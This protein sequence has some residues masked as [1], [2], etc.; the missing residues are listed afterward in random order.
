MF[1]TISILLL[2]TMLF[3]AIPAACRAQATAEDT[4]A[5]VAIS[6]PFTQMEQAFDAGNVDALT[7]LFLPTAE[8]LDEAGFAHSGHEELSALFGGFFA[9]FPGAKM[10]IEIESVREIT[11][12]LATG[13][14]IRS[15]TTA[16]GVER[17]ITRSYLTLVREGNA[18]RIAS[19]RDVAADAELSPRQQLEP[20]SWFV[21][22]WIDEGADSLI[23]IKGHWSED[24]NFLLL[25]YVIKREGEEAMASQ[26]RIGWDPLHEQLRS[27]IFDADG[28]F[29]EALWTKISD[30]W[31]VKSSA[32]LP[33]GATGSATFVI[34]PQSE[35]RFV[36]RGLDRI[37][38]DE[39]QP[40]VEMTI[41]RKPPKAE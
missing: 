33:D 19:I 20:L 22:E 10:E 35:D 31:V 9:E 24:E 16:D 18:W 2:A 26:Q 41:V 38:G 21:G 34:E 15:V 17:A 36:M 23:E 12:Q 1:R 32:V 11:P 14:V 5:E 6:Q 3:F 8:Y 13:D 40:D 28:G 7:A 27:W 4:S 30:S 29:G 39:V 37:L 25:D